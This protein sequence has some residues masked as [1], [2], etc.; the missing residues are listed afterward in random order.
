MLY[1][2]IFGSGDHE[3][4]AGGPTRVEQDGDL[5]LIPWGGVEFGTNKAAGTPILSTYDGVASGN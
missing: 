2:S 4:K 1:A 3:L 5:V